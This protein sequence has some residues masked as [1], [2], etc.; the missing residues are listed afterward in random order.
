ME[1][2]ESLEKLTSQIVGQINRLIEARN[3]ALKE[4]RGMG[5][6]LHKRKITLAYMPFFLV[7]YS[8]DLK[9]RYITFPPSV[10]NTMDGLSRIK[11]A[12]RPY[13][14]RSLLQEYSMPI[15]TLLNDFVNSLQQNSMLEDKNLKMCMKSNLLKHK[16]FQKD[17]E[18]GL[19]ELA[20]EEWLSKEELETL[21]SRL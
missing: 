12:L 13:T 3:L 15:A 17:V 11:G 21:A 7:C 1:A 14:I 19:R 20:R 10:A 4:L 16:A 6:L 9:K 18:R 8:R 5:Y 2:M